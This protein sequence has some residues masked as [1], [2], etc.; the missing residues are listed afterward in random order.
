MSSKLGNKISEG[1][2][3]EVFEWEGSHKVIKLAKENID[4]ETMNREFINNKMAWDHKLPVAR[5][6]ELLE[7]NGRPGIVYER[8]YGKPLLERFL[9]HLMVDINQ[10]V[11]LNGGDI[12]L[13][14]RTL[15]EI[16]NNSNINL[17]A[18]HREDLK[19]LI[20]SVQYLTKEEKENVISILDSL[21][22]KQLLCH[23]DPNPDNF[24]I[25]D[26]GKAV[27]IDWMNASIG[28]PEADVAEFIVMIK[29]AI[30]PPEIPSQV[31]EYFYSIREEL[32]QI[33]MEEY[34]NLTGITY[35]EIIPWLT[36]MAARKLYTADALLEE[37]KKLLVEVIR[38]DLET[39]ELTN[40]SM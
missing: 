34:T 25:G 14:A 31:S 26:D 10:K 23:G 28:N 39:R 21:P 7:I 40:K 37:E 9:G 1:S 29:Y 33:F 17:P 20:N 13:I 16:H 30:L 12:P 22:T 5:P 24:L 38:K 3:S 36:P 6:F 2:C 8:I 19:Y 32:I 15:G 11:D 27:V 35:D 4:F 18:S